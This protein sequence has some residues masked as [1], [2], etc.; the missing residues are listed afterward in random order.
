M[1]RGLTFSITTQQAQERPPS[2]NVDEG[3]A[4]LSLRFCLFTF[5]LYRRVPRVHLDGAGGLFAAD[6]VDVEAGEGR[7]VEV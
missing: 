5:D 3:R 1:N 4:V 7:G 2:I 6:L